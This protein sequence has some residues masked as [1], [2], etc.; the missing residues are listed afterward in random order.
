VE[1]QRHSDAGQR[2][3]DQVQQNREHHDGSEGEIVVHRH[4]E[5]P[6]YGAPRHAVDQADG[7]LFPESS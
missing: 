2:R 1:Q 6:R 3:D 7:E 5:H 4:R